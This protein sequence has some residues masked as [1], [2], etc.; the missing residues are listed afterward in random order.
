MQDLAIVVAEALCGMLFLI[1]FLLILKRRL[2]SHIFAIYMVVVASIYL[3]IVP[4]F[5]IISDIY[6]KS[7]NKQYLLS[8]YAQTMS[9]SLI[10]FLFPFLAS[11]IY[12]VGVFSKTNTHDSSSGILDR[13]YIAFYNTIILAVSI[14]YSTIVLKNGLLFSRI[15]PEE[16][17]RKYAE[18]PGVEFIVFRSFQEVFIP[19]LI[20]GIYFSVKYKTI[21]L[22]IPLIIMSAVYFSSNILNSRI[23]VINLFVV[24]AM[25]IIISNPWRIGKMIRALI[26]AL[27]AAALSAN[28]VVAARTTLNSAHDIDLARAVN[29]LSTQSVG[30]FGDSQGVDRINC[31]QIN[32][33]LQPYIDSRGVMLGAGWA[34]YYWTVIGRYTDPEGF[35]LYKLTFKTS[36]KT[37]ILAHYLNWN[38]T[39]YAT[40]S[41]TDMYANFGVIGLSILALIYS[42]ILAATYSIFTSK[43][44][45]MYIV[46]L[47]VILARMLSFDREGGDVIFG[48]TQYLPVYI[49]FAIFHLAIFFER[50]TVKTRRNKLSTTRYM[51][52]LSIK[53]NF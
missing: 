29:S 22:R 31:T 20:C 14:M 24:A 41:V 18:M 11:Y 53:K 40:C 49:L 26:P 52:K 50:R 46:P 10:F 17:L 45:A 28:F 48:W 1:I 27:I 21:L 32:A 42:L 35:N 16:L 12:F 9:Y 33:L 51:Y 39:D 7:S 38:V 44:V 6:S 43:K 25:L 13:K 5:S 23:A 3:L 36:S 37:I 30:L 34:N 8:S 19:L 47:S 4:S 2:P 15:G